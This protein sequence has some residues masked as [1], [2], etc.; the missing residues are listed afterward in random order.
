MK[1]YHW[2]LCVA[3]NCDWFREITVKFDSSVA[4]RGIK[5]YSKSRIELRNIKISKKMST[6][7]LS[8][9]HRL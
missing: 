3:K 8:S 9:E 6:Q 5:T 1:Q 7:S 2:L 4:S